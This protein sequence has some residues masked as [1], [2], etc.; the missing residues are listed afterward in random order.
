MWAR[1][2]ALVM[3]FALVALVFANFLVPVDLQTRVYVG[4]AWVFIAAALGIASRIVA[5]SRLH[6]S[7]RN[8]WDNRCPTCG[9]SLTA[10]TTGICPECGKSVRL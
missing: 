7:L 10:N 8:K 4:T 9:Y 5:A 6:T 2:A 3:G 1:P